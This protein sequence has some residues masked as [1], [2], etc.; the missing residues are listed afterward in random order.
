M[1][2]KFFNNLI[3]DFLP[4]IFLFTYLLINLLLI[5]FKNLKV[6]VLLGYFKLIVKFLFLFLI[7][8]LYQKSYFLN[9]YFIIDEYINFLKLII[10]ITTLFLI[11]YL[12]LI[13]N[14]KNEF[15]I[16][17]SGITFFILLFISSFNLLIF[18][19]NLIGFS[20]FIYALIM[21]E[22][23]YEKNKI[24][25]AGFKYFFMSTFSSMFIL[26]SLIWFYIIFKTVNFWE[27]KQNISYQIFCDIYLINENKIMT[28]AIIL[29]SIGFLFKLAAFP[30]HSWITEVYSGIQNIT[31]IFL[32][33]PIKI[34]SIG[35]FNRLINYIFIIL[36]EIWQPLLLFSA[37]CSMLFGSLLAFQMTLIRKFI[38]AASINQIGFIL[39]ATVLGTFEGF[40]TSF[41]YL[42]IY[43][44]MNFIFLSIYLNIKFVFNK[45]NNIQFIN[46]IDFKLIHK[47]YSQ[48]KFCLIITFFSMAG[49][50]PL[51]GFFSKY[52]VLLYTFGINGI[53]TTI[54]GLI[55][56]ILSCIYYLYIIKELIYFANVKLNETFHIIIP[57]FLKIV[58]YLSTIFLI[59]PLFFI[60]GLLTIID[61]LQNLIS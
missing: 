61:Q 28:I 6:K 45:I 1:I 21:K 22:K 43:I 27:M 36:V 54:I 18:F 42:L 46:I 59:T 53:I 37:C 57:Y 3:I 25:E 39:T 48:L 58:V 17:I 8:A 16:L 5:T 31:L 49:I 32:I 11:N 9:T 33:L 12:N 40:R 10:I 24:L 52:Y 44:L 29:F 4:E 20:I 26:F 38:A 30:F 34:A 47:N 13:K 60:N 55:I 15:L 56:S 23:L 7:N 50:P 51:A 41:F 2:F 19:I 35:I 14:L